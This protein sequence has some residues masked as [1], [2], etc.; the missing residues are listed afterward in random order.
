MLYEVI[1]IDPENF[2]LTFDSE[3]PKQLEV[4][5]A[6]ENLT[7]SPDFTVKDSQFKNCRARGVITSYSIHYTKL[8]DTAR[9]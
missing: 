3:I 2:I 9:T 8:Y 7:W 6:I 1:T 5:D 4:G